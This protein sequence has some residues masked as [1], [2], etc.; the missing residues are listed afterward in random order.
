[1]IQLKG[2]A[3]S[4]WDLADVKPKL[5]YRLLIARILERRKR[6]ADG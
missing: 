3:G 2:Q 4:D 6:P 5:I 1:M